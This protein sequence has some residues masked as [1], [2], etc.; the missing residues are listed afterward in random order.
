L[1]QAG[2]TFVS[3]HMNDRLSWYSIYHG[4]LKQKMNSFF[5]LGYLGLDY[6]LKI[7]KEEK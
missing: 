6:L 2:M 3:G 4:N 7:Q 1:W 5:A